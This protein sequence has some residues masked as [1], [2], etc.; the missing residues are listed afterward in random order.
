MTAKQGGIPT[1]LIT[2]WEFHVKK[3]SKL[4]LLIT[5]IFLLLL[6]FLPGINDYIMHILILIM[7]YIVLA[8]GL[9]IVTGL[10]GLLDLGYVGF[11]GIGA[12]TV[13]LLTVKFAMADNWLSI[14]GNF[15]FLV[16]LAILH[17]ALWGIILGIPTLR[18]SGDYFAIVTFG[19]SELVILV[20]TN[21]VWLT[22]GPSGVPGILPPSIGNYV[23]TGKEPF[24]YLILFF[25]IIVIY[26]V[27]R[28]QS[29]YVGRAWVAIR[30]DEIAAES[31]G[32]NIMKFKIYA[33]AMSASIG[34]LGGAFY[35][36][37]MMFI[38]PKMFQ[39]WESVIILCMIVLGGMGSIAGVIA[40]AITLTSLGE[41]LR[42]ILTRFGLPAESRHL[43]FGLIMILIMRYRP[44]GLYP[45]KGHRP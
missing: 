21:E 36:R 24:Y 37:W 1:L 11:Y 7:L 44:E 19:F 30:E 13:G 26:I 23:F 15:W 6:P 42:E 2:H 18:L 35:A 10:A 22:N 40:G 4:S 45:A 5:F 8:L 38:G 41:I 9:N 27:H 39:F 12:Y 31:M 34:A 32:I 17:G 25:V 20:I 28:F 14:F 33:F 29:S 16:I 3:K 43:F